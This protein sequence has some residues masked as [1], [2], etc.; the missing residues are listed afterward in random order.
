MKVACATAPLSGSFRRFFP[1]L[2]I[3]GHESNV[4]SD[5][6]LLI[7]TGGSDL[8]P[9]LYHQTPNGAVGWDT[10]RD[11]REINIIREIRNVN[12]GTKI[13][14]VCRGLQ[15]L[16]VYLGGSLFQDIDSI[17][18]AH[19]GVHPLGFNN[20]DHPLAWL[21]VTNSLHHQA[22]ASLG[23]GFGSLP[24]VIAIEPRT[25]LCEIVGWGDSALGVQFH[26]EMFSDEIGKHFFSVIED[27]VKGSVSL[28]DE[29]DSYDE[30]ESQDDD[31]S[32]E[33]EETRS[34][35]I[36]NES[37]ERHIFGTAT[38]SWTGTSFTAAW[39]APESGAT[40]TSTIGDNND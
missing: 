5:I 25:N 22:V 14:G 7:L 26:P 39:R 35:E 34:E 17:G 23:D 30:E 37:S 36:D 3:I 2:T 10:E 32:D 12:S 27:W 18:K 31:D 15:L 9:N 16:N 38:S 33:E 24:D 13:L 8:N 19:H 4:K 1:D 28:V 11:T 29:E 6:D 20:P 21:T 40:M